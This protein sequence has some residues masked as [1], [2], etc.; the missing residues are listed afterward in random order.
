MMSR[1]ESPKE[2]WQTELNEKKIS[3]RTR[4]DIFC[5]YDLVKVVLLQFGQGG[6]LSSA[7]SLRL[8]PQLQQV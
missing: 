1:R 6:I 2:N 8:N 5:S 3:V 7:P 4:T